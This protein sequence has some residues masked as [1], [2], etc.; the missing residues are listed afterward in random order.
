MSAF[1]YFVFLWTLT[2]AVS[3]LSGC[4]ISSKDS[5]V[6]LY[7]CL[8]CW[9]FPSLLCEAQLSRKN[10][11]PPWGLKIKKPTPL[12]LSSIWLGWKSQPECYSAFLNHILGSFSLGHCRNFREIASASAE[13]RGSRS[14]LNL[15]SLFWHSFS[16]VTTL[17]KEQVS[18]AEL[19]KTTASECPIFQ[20]IIPNVF[21]AFKLVPFEGLIKKNN[22]FTT[23]FQ[24]NKS[25]AISGWTVC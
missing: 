20:F 13:P 18:R 12:K 7:F 1:L 10:K 21:V 3:R 14:W 24:G 16:I 5:V 17:V 2:S 8:L 25:F 6:F 9:L 15:L 22:V 11:I 4:S 19:W 23:F